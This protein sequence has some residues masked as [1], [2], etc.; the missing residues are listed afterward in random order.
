VN[1]QFTAQGIYLPDIDLWLDPQERC[2]NSWISH[3]HSDHARE[4]HCTVIATP[5]TLRV[6]RIRWPEDTSSPQRLHPL[7]YGESLEWRGATLTAYPA[8][9][10][11]GAAQL[12]VEYGG[13]RLVY[14]GDIKR[15]P[16]ICGVETQTV[17]C[18]RLI[19]ESTFGLPIF[20]FLSREEA[21]ERILAF[22]RE[23]L[24]DGITPVFIGYPLGRGQEAAHVLCRAGIPTA[25]H[26]A[27][28][29]MIPAYEESG[30]TFPGWMPY[31]ARETAGKA[32]VVVPGFRA[33]LEASGKNMRVAYMSGW[34]A[35]DNARSRAGAE[36]LIPY[37][38]HAGFDELLELVSES[39]ADEVDVVHGFTE[40]FARILNQRGI[41]ARA[42]R[43][44]AARDQ[45]DEV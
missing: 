40:P 17:P 32:L 45:A 6:Y 10:I 25:I 44:A 42:P 29:R 36:E 20:R 24:E 27:I 14:T 38:D 21:V 33:T 15:R 12:L 30:F 37:S 4:L 43:A 7:H 16:P 2:E 18:D 41:R 8:S 11:L 3:G 39:G 31:D 26:G 13:E 19:I 1:V 34:A 35:L 5:E 23:C 22:A 28:A 9:H